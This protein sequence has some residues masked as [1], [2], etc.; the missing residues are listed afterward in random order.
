MDS[1]WSIG[2]EWMYSPWDTLIGTTLKDVNDV[3]LK[4]E[5]VV[6][7]KKEHMKLATDLCVS[8]FHSVMQGCNSICSNKD[9]HINMCLATTPVT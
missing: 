8:N 2:R 5:Q 4:N 9:M 1:W 7:V 3:K 6:E